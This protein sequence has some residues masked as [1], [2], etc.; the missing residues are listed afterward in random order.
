MGD[1]ST[2]TDGFG[3]S[4]VEISQRTEEKCQ[5]LAQLGFSREAGR[6]IGNLWVSGQLTLGFEELTMTRI[7]QRIDQEDNNRTGPIGLDANLN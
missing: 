6:E 5:L 7:G 3:A 2:P 4:E 1:G